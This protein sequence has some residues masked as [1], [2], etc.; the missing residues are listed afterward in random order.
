MFNPVKIKEN[1]YWVGAIDWDLRVCG[2]YNTPYG[3]TYNAYLILDDK[4]TLIDTVKTGFETEMFSRIKEIINPSRIDYL[5]CQHAERDHSGAIPALLVAAPKA[6]IVATQLCKDALF[7]HFGKGLPYH[8]IVRTNDTL[9]TGRNNFRFIEAKMLHWPDNMLTYC[10]EEKILFSNDV[11]G[12][13]M[14]SS[15]RFDDEA[16]HLWM[17]EATKYFAVIVSVY[18]PL[19]RTK[20]EEIEKMNLEIEMIAPAHGLIWRRPKVIIDAYRRWS[21]GEAQQKIVIAYDTMWQ[22]TEKMAYEIARGIMEEGVEVKVFNLRASD[23]TLIIKEII[24]SRL[25]LIGSPTLNTGMYPS[26]GGFLTFLRG[27]RPV[28]KKAAAFGSFGWGKGAVSQIEEELRSMRFEVLE[29]IEI[30][31]VPHQKELEICFEFGRKSG[32]LVKKGDS[33]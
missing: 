5:I 10:K 16:D 15:W 22:S 4:V 30:K 2:S 25:I 21:S 29:G 19:V 23:W 24:E 33:I 18:A 14:A 17:S 28:N 31:Y 9:N 12:G 32:L 27:I 8:K 11:F 20:L 7:N 13:H 6:K 3:T 26:V 1:L